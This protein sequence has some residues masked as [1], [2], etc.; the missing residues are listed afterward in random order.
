MCLVSVA[1]F[2]LTP[3]VTLPP[4]AENGSDSEG[5]VDMG[6]LGEPNGD[7]AP[8][9]PAFDPRAGLVAP[10]DSSDD[11]A[12]TTAGTA[13]TRSA[14]AAG[15]PAASAG[16]AAAGAAAAG[17][18]APALEDVRCFGRVLRSSAPQTPGARAT[19]T[20]LRLTSSTVLT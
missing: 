11:E 16:A 7:D 13:A 15:A 14:P 18:P 1:S 5:D 3:R 19:T 4:D 10:E 17:A 20:T 6:A 9:A 8:A 2:P 12:D